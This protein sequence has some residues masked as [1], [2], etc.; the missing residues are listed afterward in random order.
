MRNEIGVF[1]MMI[2]AMG[3]DSEKLLLPLAIIV[4]SAILI[5]YREK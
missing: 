1:L 5:F 2:G 4:L 3:G